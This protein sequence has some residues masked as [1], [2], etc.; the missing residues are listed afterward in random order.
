MTPLI[1]TTA[2]LADLNSPIVW[3]LALIPLTAPA[4]MLQVLTLSDQPPLLMIGLS[5]L[6]LTA[7]VVIA[8]LAA[9]R[10]FRATLLLYGVRPGVRQIVDA[11]RARS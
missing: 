11:I 3:V 4:T 5:L 1:F 7:F 10:V 9:A 8:T 6:S 2:L